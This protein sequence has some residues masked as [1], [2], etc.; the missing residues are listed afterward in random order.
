MADESARGERLGIRL[1]IEGIELP[2]ASANVRAQ[3]MGPA[4]ASFSVPAAEGVLSIKPRSLVHLFYYNNNTYH[5]PV[6]ESSGALF[7]DSAL[8]TE[9]DIESP[10]AMK[11]ENPHRWNLLFVGEILGY[12]YVKDV[13]GE[14]I[15]FQARDFTQY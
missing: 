10:T 6:A 12:Q 1:F 4:Q 11:L 8:N 13:S 9:G 2:V 5:S 15:N 14:R 7:A 3:M